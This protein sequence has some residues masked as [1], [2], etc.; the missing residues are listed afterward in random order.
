MD[1]A[2]QKVQQHF[3]RGGQTVIPRAH[4]QRRVDDD[5]RHAASCGLEGLLLGQKLGAAIRS[6]HLLQS[7]HDGLVNNAA[8]VSSTSRLEYGLGGGVDD[9]FY[10]PTL[11]LGEHDFCA[12]VIDAHEVVL[13]ARP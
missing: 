7:S 12:L 5:H 11:G 8:A 6:G 10:L 4:R 3:R 9:A 2:V 13:V 1:L